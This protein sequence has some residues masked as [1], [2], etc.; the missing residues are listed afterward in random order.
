MK[1]QQLL[2]TYQ[3]H[4]YKTLISAEVDTAFEF[5]YLAILTYGDLYYQQALEFAQKASNLEPDNPVYFQSVLYLK[6]VLKDGK[7]GVYVTPDGFTSFIRGG[8]NLPL[9]EKLSQKLKQIYQELSKLSLLDIG[10]GD[11]RALIP[12]ITENIYQL[13]FVEPSQAMHD[14]FCAVLKQKATQFN[15]FNSSVQDY[16]KKH[17]GDW[18]IIQS[19]F[20]IQSLEQEDRT[21]LFKWIRQNGKRL[22][23]A[24]FNVPD[25]EE[26]YSPE[27]FTYVITHYLN[28]LKEYPDDLAAIQ[29]FLIPVMFGYFD[30][31]KA[32]TNYEQP[33][34]KWCDEIKAAGFK[35]INKQVIYPYW[36]ADAYL[37]D[38]E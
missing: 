3:K 9:Y 33:I 24:E 14:D 35:K 1:L 16:I 27:K 15:S 36:W 30:R 12:A 11:G 32:R 2:Q 37:I 26:I 21:E 38:A 22:V 31:T 13:D 25:F 7:N 20:C 4:G 6:Q 19:T 18:D 10:A 23:I 28:G 34:D 8:G 29:G 5:F 17:K